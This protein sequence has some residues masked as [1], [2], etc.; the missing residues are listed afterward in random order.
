MNRLSKWLM[1]FILFFGASF[2]LANEKNE[3]RIDSVK[4]KFSE[5][6]VTANRYEKNLFETHIPVSI[7]KRI[8]IWQKGFS[9]VGEILN[10]QAGV[11]FTSAGPWSQ[12]PVIR[13]LVGSHVL[14]LIDGMRVS[15]L[16][17][18][19]SHA[20]LLDAS[21]IE[22]IEII[23]GPASILYG[24]D[25]IAGVIN[26]ITYKPESFSNDF[27]LSGNASFQYNSVNQQ[28]NENISIKGSFKNLSLQLGFSNRKAEDV[29]TPVGVLKNTAFSG[30]TFDAKIGL[31]ITKKHRISLSGQSDRFSDVGVPI[32]PFASQA[33]FLSYDRDLLSLNYDYRSPESW[34]TNSKVQVFYQKGKR[35]FDALI[36]GVPKGALF[37][38]QA[39]TANRDVESFGGSVQNRINILPKNL[40][41][42]GV[43]FFAEFDDTR[44]VADAEIY[45]SAGD[46]VKNPPADL[47]P[48]TPKSDRRGIAFFVEDEF[49]ITHRLNFTLGA[50]IDEIKSHAE[51]TPNTLVETTIDKTDRDVS[52]NFGFLYRIN[53]NLRLT[54]NVG[55]AFKAPTLQERFFKGT[56]QV[57]YLFGNPDLKS[58]TSLN[59]DAGLKIKYERISGEFTI[60][61]NQINDLIVMK[62]ISANADTFL[63]DNV[64]K[65]EIFGGEAEVKFKI[66]RT[67][68]FFANTAYV[69]GQDVNLDEPLP[70]MP[71][72]TTLL[73]LRF[74]MPEQKLW[75]ELAARIVD[76]QN[77]VAENE[78]ETPG[79]TLFDFSSGVNLGAFFRTPL[80]LQL[81]FN[82][83]N[84]LDRD[85]RDH[86]SSVNWWSAPGRNISVGLKTNF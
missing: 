50:R 64:G 18:Y 11:T 67:L 10:K 57:G 81:T 58:E 25:A 77:R 28:H 84:L 36:E 60:F 2:L 56:A 8:N 82:I 51:A 5:I 40:L 86:L 9:S 3:A 49:Q 1:F 29:S 53:S 26:Y 43:D 19:G 23:R 17:D 13:G 21:Q 44:R 15:N 27:V 7:S 85:Y 59:I 55:R 80:P 31:R 79:Y 20:P 38:R 83:H 33:K 72:L 74:E 76:T 54:A 69:H 4:Y 34:W 52:G 6:V 16:R 70:K 37:V 32:N 22:K 24:S 46:I 73:G 62:P 75:L 35:N 14:T 68:S 30:K 42:F 47:T 66:N 39:L 78:N 61:R 12:K 41:T 48:P 71:P 65:A 63:Y 45:S